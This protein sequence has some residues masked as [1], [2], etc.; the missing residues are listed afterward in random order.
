MS[1]SPIFQFAD[2][3]QDTA[4]AQADFWVWV[5]QTGRGRW[6]P[7][8]SQRGVLGL[9]DILPPNTELCMVIPGPNEMFQ[10]DRNVVFAAAG[11][12]EI[13]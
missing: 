3:D 7:R 10:E 9:P 12:R 11:L 5:V 6:R 8:L 1:L 4:Q 13:K 2:V